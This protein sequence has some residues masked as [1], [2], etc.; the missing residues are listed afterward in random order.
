MSIE[1]T[2]CP[3]EFSRDVVAVARQG[4]QSTAKV[5]WSFGMTTRRRHLHGPRTGRPSTVR[6][7]W[8]KPAH[9]DASPASCSGWEQRLDG[10]GGWHGRV[11]H[12]GG[13][14]RRLGHRGGVAA[15]WPA[16][17]GGTVD[18]PNSAEGVSEG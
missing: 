3:R 7:C 13:E 8:T 10:A 2:P 6:H 15:G 5:A 1:P 16:R 11:E 12:P 4:D 17:A 9:T 18:D 14:A